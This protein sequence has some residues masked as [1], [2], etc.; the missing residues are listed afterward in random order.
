MSLQGHSQTSF[1]GLG[2]FTRFLRTERKQ[3]SLLL[4]EGKEGRYWELQASQPCL[5]P[6]EGDKQILLGVTGK[7][8]E[9]RR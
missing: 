4:L 1:K 9:T 2:N 6:W 8:V 3:M 5:D 7:C